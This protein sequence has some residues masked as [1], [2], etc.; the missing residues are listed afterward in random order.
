MY[1]LRR[2]IQPEITQYDYGYEEDDFDHP[3]SDPNSRSQTRGK[4]MKFIFMNSTETRD[5]KATSNQKLLSLKKGI[6]S[7]EG[8]YPTLKDEIL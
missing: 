6:K 7:K 5:F 2:H 3:L 4:Y 1:N 8:A